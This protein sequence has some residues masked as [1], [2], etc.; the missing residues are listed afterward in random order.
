MY[1][2]KWVRSNYG[3]LCLLGLGFLDFSLY[4]S[5]TPAHEGWPPSGVSSSWLSS[6]FLPSWGVWHPAC[7]SLS[8]GWEYSLYQVLPSSDDPHLASPGWGGHDCQGRMGTGAGGPLD[9]SAYRGLV[10]TRTA[11]GR[12]KSLLKG[13]TLSGVWI[14][15]HFMHTNYS[16]QKK[17]EVEVDEQSQGRPEQ[18][19]TI[20]SQLPTA[21]C[22]LVPETPIPA[23]FCLLFTF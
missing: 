23:P 21:V 10:G 17:T 3:G 19:E 2:E 18:S 7:H 20:S 8:A 1:L 22:F 16:F 6:P 14:R 13:K 11:A 9:P 4:P 12:G 15:D 5:S